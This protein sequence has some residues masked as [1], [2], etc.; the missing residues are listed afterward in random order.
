MMK[1]AIKSIPT[2][3]LLARKYY[4]L[5][6]IGRHKLILEYLAKDKDIAGIENQ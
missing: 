1:N 2:V 3:N 6:I 4:K 5:D